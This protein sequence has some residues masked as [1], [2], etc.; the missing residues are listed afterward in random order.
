[1][2]LNLR[3]LF[4]QLSSD[5]SV[6]AI[7]LS[8]AGPRA[9]TAGLDINAA[10][11]GPLTGSGSD[12]GRR[13]RALMEHIHEFQSCISAIEACSKPVIAA[14]HGIAFG[15]AID[16]SC[17]CDIRLIASQGT[18]LSVKEV[19]IGLA[20]DI[21]T[22]SRLPKVVGNHSWVKEVALSAREFGADEADKVGFARKVQ[23]GKEEVVAEATKLAGL[24]ASKSPV[25]VWGTKEILNWSRDRTTEDGLKYTAVWNGAMLQASDVKEALGAAVMKKKAKFEKL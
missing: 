13:A 5:S 7:I 3:T 4:T 10:S 20:A 25:A 11:Q 18:R 12:P 24:I 23:G 21:G 14:I 1:M 8:G 2:W 9:F 16:I 19:D 17:A 22:L 15:L 6:R